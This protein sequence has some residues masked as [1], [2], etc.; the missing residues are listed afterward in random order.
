[1]VLT[2]QNLILNSHFCMFFNFHF[3][4]MFLL[5]SVMLKWCNSACTNIHIWCNYII[6]L[7]FHLFEHACISRILV[8]W[9]ASESRTWCFSTLYV[10]C[11]LLHHLIS[12]W[13]LFYILFYLPSLS[14][15][16]QGCLRIQ[17]RRQAYGILF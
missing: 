2:L 7:F 10:C 5:S 3:V 11:M 13:P 12:C 8:I 14:C 15:E 17:C 1:M 4:T 9:Y 16:I 6:I